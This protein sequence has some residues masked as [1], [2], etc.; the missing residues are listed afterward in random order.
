MRK[1]L[2]PARIECSGS[3]K[4]A[5][6]ATFYIWVPEYLADDKDFLGAVEDILLKQGW[7]ATSIK[8]CVIHTDPHD[9]DEY[10]YVVEERVPD[11]CFSNVQKCRRIEVYCDNKLYNDAIAE[12][13]NERRTNI[14]KNCNALKVVDYKNFVL[15]IRM[16]GIKVY[17]TDDAELAHKFCDSI[18][19]ENNEVRNY[20]DLISNKDA[21]FGAY[22]CSEP[23]SASLFYGDIYLLESMDKTTAVRM[24]GRDMNRWFMKTLD[25]YYAIKK[26]VISFGD[27]LVGDNDYIPIDEIERI[28]IDFEPYNRGL[29]DRHDYV[30]TPLLSKPYLGTITAKPYIKYGDWNIVLCPDD[31]IC[32]LLNMWQNV[33]FDEDIEYAKQKERYK[34]IQAQIQAEIEEGESDDEDE[35]DESDDE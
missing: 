23:D 12:R 3:W 20:H 21:F 24:R 9:Y 27:K 19:A 6:H 11:V 1:E 29:F 2:E 15:V 25:E 4:E 14:F 30:I 13:A 22:V 5:P 8:N 17:C 26:K 35:E 33:E 10:E 18:R 32:V 28:K 7:V 34:K 16:S 31:P